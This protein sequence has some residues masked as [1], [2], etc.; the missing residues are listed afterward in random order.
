MEIIQVKDKNTIE[1]FHKLPIVIYKNDHNWVLSLQMMIEDVFD[2]TKN[3]G[4]LNGDA[5]RWIVKNGDTIIGRIAAFYDRSKWEEGSEPAGGIGYFEC[6]DNQMAA[7]ML[8]DTARDWLCE[9]GITAMDGPINFGEN[10][11][12]WGLLVDGFQQQ[13]FGM[14]YHLPYYKK[15]FTQYGFET[16]YQQ[17]SYHLDITSPD[18]PERFWKIAAWVAQKKDFHFKAF[19]FK[20]QDRCID[21]FITI[22]QQAWNKHS[23]YKQIERDELKALIRDAKM[24]LDEE[25][26]WYVYHKEKPIAFF[27]MI[28]DLNQILQHLRSG[29]LNLGNILKLLY[30]KQRKKI[31]RCRVLVMGVVPSFQ[32][33]GIESGIFWQIRQVLL[34]K[35]QYNEMELSWVGDFNPKMISLFKAVGSQYAK[36]H[37]TMRYLFDRNRPF[38]RLPIIED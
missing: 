19:S 7:N 27:M 23:N 3:A 2:T 9:Q 21:D 11:F 31:N 24:V 33:S 22:H 15:L 28:P 32:R 35:A 38:E 29:K 12:N 10:F 18:L 14:Q 25:F 5:R 34:R 26:I 4:F 37:E 17:F 30:L 8:F 36:T 13:G 6:F 1:A 16:Y 20:E